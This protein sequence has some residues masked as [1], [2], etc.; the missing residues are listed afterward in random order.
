[1]AEMVQ[2]GTTGALVRGSSPGEAGLADAMLRYLRDPAMRA[3]QGHAGRQRV[4]REFEAAAQARKIQ[5]EIVRASGL[6][7]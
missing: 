4:L 7:R 5:D 6:A 3:R 1:V 2:D